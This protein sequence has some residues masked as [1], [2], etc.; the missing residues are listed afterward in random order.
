M[1]ICGTSSIKLSIKHAVAFGV[2][3]LPNSQGPSD[4]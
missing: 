1:M 4:C 3:T 2:P